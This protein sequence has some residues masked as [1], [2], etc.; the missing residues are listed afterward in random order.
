[1]SEEAT[2]GEQVWAVGH[3][4]VDDIVLWDGTINLGT[5]GGAAL[6]AAYG[7][8]LLGARSRIATRLGRGYPVAEFSGRGR[9][10]ITV[11]PEDAAGGSIHQWVLYEKDGTRAYVPHPGSGTTDAMSPAPGRHRIPA[12]APVHLAPMPIARQ[13]PWCRS[14]V[15]RSGI[16]TLDP[17]ADSC[18]SDPD[19]VLATV[20]YSTAFLPSELESVAL[21]GDNPVRAV[22]KFREAGAPIAVVKLGAEGSVVATPDGVWRVPAATVRVV[23]PT[24]AG[25]AYCGAFAAALH[26][27]LGGVDAARA[28]TA[29]AAEIVQVKGAGIES[30]TEARQA[31]ATRTASI[32]PILLTRDSG[33]TTRATNE[34]ADERV[35]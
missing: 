34:R 15:G 2:G 35:I 29:V 22:R 33:G 9:F 25:D 3:L 27:G 11:D 32:T 18:A 17:H 4:T 7:A 14:L 31:V 8:S 26:R 10:G 30:F 13:L 20:R 24:G 12:S 28:A 23:D 19:D 16:L 21:A 1:M 5:P 6:Y